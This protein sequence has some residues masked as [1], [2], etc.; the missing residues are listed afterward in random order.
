MLVIVLRARDLERVL[1][2]LLRL[3]DAAQRL[4][5][6][7]TSF[8]FTMAMA[9]LGLVL[10]VVFAAPIADL[11]GLDDP[12]LVRAGFVGAVGADELRAADGALP[13]RGALGRVRDREPRERR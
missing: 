3:E 4:L 12:N 11:L 2:L 13:R 10:G 8:W 1:P 7:R 9:T 6:V 5:V